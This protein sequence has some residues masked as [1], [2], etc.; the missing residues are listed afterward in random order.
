MEAGT[1]SIRKA[2]DWI[3]VKAGKS[4]SHQGLVK[5]HQQYRPDSDRLKTRELKRQL[6]NKEEFPEKREKK[7]LS[8]LK[9]NWLV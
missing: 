6:E 1:L 4:I 2:V 9:S 7:R 8:R 3:T 5:L